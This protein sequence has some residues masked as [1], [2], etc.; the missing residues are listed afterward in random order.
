MNE[1]QPPNVMPGPGIDPVTAPSAPPKRGAKRW[2]WIILG[3]LVVVSIIW[4]V[5][6]MA[7]KTEAPGTEESSAAQKMLD[8]MFTA[9]AAKTKVHLEYAERQYDSKADQAAGTVKDQFFSAGELDSSTKEY[10][11]VYADQQ[12]TGIGPTYALVRCQNGNMYKPAASAYSF[13]TWIDVKN[14][15]AQPFTA[16]TP[17]DTAEGQNCSVDYPKHLG[18]VTDGVIPVGLNQEQITDWLN[19]LHESNFIQ[20]KD[21]GVTQYAKRQVRKLHITTNSLAGTGSFYSAVQQGAGLQLETDS[22]E[23]GLD[24]YRFEHMSTSDNIDGFYLVDQETNLPVFSEFTSLGLKVEDQKS[25][26][27]LKHLYAY[28]DQ[29]FLNERATLNPLE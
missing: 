28:P 8:D 14:A 25:G 2:L 21:E 22:G 15:L 3:I 23:A 17:A 7:S 6:S 27:V 11:A 18:R 4:F 19:N 13:K 29:L 20:V 24:S 5:V 1:E 26:K 10:R 16:V 9:A 12:N